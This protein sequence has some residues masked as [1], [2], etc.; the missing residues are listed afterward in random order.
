M[1]LIFGIIIR[2]SAVNLQKKIF[3]N[4]RGLFKL[5]IPGIFLIECILHHEI[6]NN[7]LLFSLEYNLGPFPVNDAFKYKMFKKIEYKNL[8]L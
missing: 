2:D 6:Y 4:Q 8:K 7:T 3:F 1:A 5:Q